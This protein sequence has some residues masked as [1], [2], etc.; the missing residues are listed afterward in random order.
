MCTFTAIIY[1]LVKHIIYILL[2]VFLISCANKKE[3][4]VDISEGKTKLSIAKEHSALEEVKPAF[5]KDVEFWKDLKV[6]TDFIKEFEK[7]SPYEA[8]S[9]AVELKDLVLNLRDSLK[10]K[11]FD[12]PSFDARVN[13]LYNE[14]LRLADLTL[15]PAITPEE[16]NKQVDK[17]ID[18]FSSVNSKINIVLSKKKFEDEIEVDVD[19]IGID[20]TKIDSVSKKAI[21]LKDK[22]KLPKIDKKNK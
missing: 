15:I 20:S 18:A 7:V 21:N 16:V 3:E 22:R 19:F 1:S 2:S 9:N 4:S 13:V 17:T 5:K 12:I 8:L 11:I 10:P 6:A 14:T